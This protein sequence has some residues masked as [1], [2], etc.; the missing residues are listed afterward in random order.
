MANETPM[1]IEEFR[2]RLSAAGLVVPAAREAELMDGL[3]HLQ[4]L[5]AR[6]HKPYG[7][8]DEPAHT[9]QAREDAL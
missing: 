2:R 4:A 8:A 9:F 5:A 7:Y 1:P 6:L 3:V